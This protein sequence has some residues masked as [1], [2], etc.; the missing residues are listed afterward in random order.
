MCPRATPTRGT[1]NSLCEIPDKSPAGSFDNENTFNSLC[2]IHRI[3]RWESEHQGHLSI[4]FVRFQEID[5]WN[6]ELR[7]TFNSLCEIH[8]GTPRYPNLSYISFNSLCEIPQMKVEKE[9]EELEAFNSLC[10]IPWWLQW[11]SSEE[12]S[13]FQFSLWDSG[14]LSLR[15]HRLIENFQFSLWDSKAY[16][17]TTGLYAIV[18]FNSL[19]EIHLMREW[20]E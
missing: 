20:T 1:F 18:T 13:S 14:V 2:E 10:E 7:E 19:C 17:E 4:L 15:I 6:D 11:I 12:D 5:V 8:Y 3:G 9:E 16:S